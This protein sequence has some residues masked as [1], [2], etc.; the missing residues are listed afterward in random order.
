MIGRTPEYFPALAGCLASYLGS[1]IKRPISDSTALKKSFRFYSDK[2]DTYFHYP[3]MLMTA[4]HFYKIKDLRKEMQIPDSCKVFLDSGGYQ[5]ATGQLNEEKFN[6]ATSFE[7]C[8][9]NGDIFPILDRPSWP[10]TDINRQ[11]ALTLEAGKFA[12]DA[13]SREGKTILNVISGSSMPIISSAYD[14]M[15]DLPFEGWAHGGHAFRMKIIL[16][17]M[18]M[19]WQ[20]GEYDR[21]HPVYHH[22]FGITSAHAIIYLTYVQRLFNEKGVDIQITYDSSSWA[23]SMGFGNLML[24]GDFNKF[25][26]INLSNRFDYSNTPPN[27]KLPCPCPVCQSV[28]SLQ[29]L[30]EDPRAYYVIGTIHNLYVQLEHM[31]QVEGWVMMGCDDVLF[32]GLPVAVTR[33]LKAIK[34][35]WDNPKRGNSII[36]HGFTALDDKH[37]DMTETKL[38]QFFD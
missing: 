23:R 21:D 16:K 5:L 15:K 28:D 1:R 36:D 17:T 34:K 32:S 4:G 2:E 30:M 12:A 10:G 13:R 38:D 31:K 6:N 37:T 25:G 9:R 24:F 19:L 8:E 33:N 18:L 22:V 7:W 3:Y 35:A 20:K 27:F 14:K 11:Q 29:E 26:T